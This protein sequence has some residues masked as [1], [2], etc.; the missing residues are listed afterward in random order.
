MFRCVFGVF[1]WW[2]NKMEE[3]E[4]D[5][6]CIDSPK[7]PR[8]TSTQPSSCIRTIFPLLGC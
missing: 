7:V 4:K 8:L 3:K 6:K 2:E 5:D 1:D